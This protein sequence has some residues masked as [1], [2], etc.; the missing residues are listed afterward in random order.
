MMQ[1]TPAPIAAA[2]ADSR[3]RGKRTRAARTDCP[4]LRSADPRRVQGLSRLGNSMGIKPVMYFTL[5]LSA[6]FSAGCSKEASRVPATGTTAAKATTSAPG[7]KQRAR[8]CDMVTPSEMSAILGSAVAAAAGSNERPPSQTECDYSSVA[9][10]SPYAE[11]EIDWGGGDQQALGTAA[12]LANGAAAGAAGQ[13]QG[14]GERAYQVTPFQ[15]FISTQGNLMM[16]RFEPG[17]K[18]VIPMARRIYETAKTRM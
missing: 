16:I 5:F 14:L 10:S 17:T 6:V 13:L 1:G 8:A 4:M 3:H 11:L 7:Q 18:D 15:V 2:G 9:G 12:G